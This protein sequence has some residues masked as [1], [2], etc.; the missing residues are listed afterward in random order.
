[1]VAS[2]STAA[3]NYFDDS[4]S[5]WQQ[6]FQICYEL[7]KEHPHQHLDMTAPPESRIATQD[8]EMQAPP[9]D[10]N[11]GLTMYQ[12]EPE[13]IE[14]EKLFQHLVN[15]S[16]HDPKLKDSAHQPSQ[17]LDIKMS[18]EH[19]KWLAPTSLDHMVQDVV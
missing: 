7:A 18:K 9:V 1:M 2:L 5:L 16:C 10:T 17:Y 19:K 8:M 4:R 14:G 11:A 13:S 6:K 15:Y 3:W 12:L